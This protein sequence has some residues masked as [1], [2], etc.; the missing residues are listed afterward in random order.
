MGIRTY[1]KDHLKELAQPL[2][3]VPVPALASEPDS[4]DPLRF[5]TRH[6]REPILVDLHVFKNGASRK[7][8]KGSWSGPFTGRPA[9]IAQLAPVIRELVEY[10]APNT[11]VQY[12]V[13]LRSWW[14]LFD[15]VEAVAENSGAHIPPVNS[16]ACITEIHRQRALDI[17]MNRASFHPFIRVLNIARKVQKMPHLY[18]DLPNNTRRGRHLPPKRQVDQVRFALKR[19]WF[20]AVSRWQQ[21]ERLLGGNEPQTEEEIN[22]F[23][24]YRLFKSAMLRADH[25]RPLAAEIMRDLPFGNG[26]CSSYN[27]PSMLRGFYP[28][29]RDIRMAFHLCLAN[30]GWNPCVLLSLDANDRFIE[31]H[32]KDPARYLMR[33]Y[34]ARGKSVQITEGLLKSQ[35]SAGGVLLA[36]MKRTEPL[37][38]QLR[39]ELVANKEEY[40]A[41]KARGASQVTLDAR[42]RQIINLEQGVRSPWLYVTSTANSVVWLKETNYMRSISGNREASF[43]NDLIEDINK[44]RAPDQQLSS[45]TATDFRDAFAAY[46]YE[47]SG[48]MVLY[49]M[50]A[51]GHKSPTTSQIYLDNTLL[52]DQSNRLYRTFSNA[53]WHEIQFYHRVDPTVVAK[54]SRDGNVTDEERERLNDYR[55]LQRSRIGVGCKDPTHPPKRIAP[56]FDADGQA[57]CPVQRCTLCLEHAVIF[58]DSL[59]GLC[60]RLAELRFIHSRVSAV[61]FL[62]SSFGEE[63]ENTELALSCFDANMVQNH[64]AD[65]ERR[66]ANG[67]HRVLEFDGI[68]RV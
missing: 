30:T 20:N 36:L 66:I 44:R 21:A 46:A 40:E 42:R 50:K 58:P 68:Q 9:L 16:V 47:T 24:N 31:P 35:G 6:P 41:L 54:W 39:K 3:A 59:D 4:D 38:T 23:N 17:G 27:I 2:A 13:S 49:V 61:S 45:F 25:P 63:I 18:W 29:A 33:G 5:W 34:K 14:R 57:L 11:A 15:E 60:K 7:P 1:K 55:S 19:G 62:E 67:E 10:A 12:I 32:P 56:S 37:R 48:G 64:L 65:W 51:L 43:L 52:N 26:E 8:R 53:L 22:L 28:D